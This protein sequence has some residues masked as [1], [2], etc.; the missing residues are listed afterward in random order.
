[1]T[2]SFEYFSTMVVV[3]PPVK[4][5]EQKLNK[6]LHLALVEVNYFNFQTLFQTK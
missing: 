4:P 5:P 3:L 1:M 2:V 6:Y